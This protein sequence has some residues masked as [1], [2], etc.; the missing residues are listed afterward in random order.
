MLIRFSV[1]NFMSFKEMQIFSMAAG[2]HTK[3][4]DHVVDANGKRVLKG[5]FFFGANASGKSNFFEAFKFAKKVVKDGLRQ[6]ILSNKHFRIMAE[7]SKRPGVFQFDIYTNGHFYSYGFAVS[8]EN[9]IIVEEWLY[10]CDSVELSIFER[11]NENGINIV[12]TGYEFSEPEQKQSFK[13][14]SENVPDDKLLLSEISERKLSE[15]VDFSSFKD[16]KNWFQGLMLISPRTQYID[17]SR[18]L[19][20]DEKEY[21]LARY[22][23]EFDTGIE[24]ISLSEQKIEDALDFVPAEVRA[25]IL[26][27]VETSFNEKDASGQKAIE[28]EIN[29]SGRILSFRMKNGQILASQ[30]LMDHGNKSDLFELADESDGTQRLF[31]LIPIYH[32]G[33]TPKVIIVDELDRSFHTKLVTK[34]ISSF[35]QI[36]AGIE[37][38]LI[39][40]VHDANVMDLDLLRQD[41]IWFVER[42]TDHSS[43]IYSLNKFKARF[44]KKVMKD[45]LLGRY[46]AIP[47]FEQSENPSELA[48]D[49]GDTNDDIT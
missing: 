35:Y 6:N 29:F 38:Q 3:H 30:L 48:E 2:K 12:E 31:D 28:V 27:D 8:Y 14:F 7:Y 44:D 43:K 23:R 25:E 39:A 18:M 1:E 10:L 21:N 5:S 26:Q 9:A 40:T 45:Y 37:S 4:S 15:H 42:Q 22:L 19:N 47:C 34:F 36:T 20:K 11:K 46:G 33:K 32:A 13:V 41:E 17:K 49:T 16:V 24:D